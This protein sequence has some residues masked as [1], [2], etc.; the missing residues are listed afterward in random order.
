MIV[1]S[2]RPLEKQPDLK[3]IIEELKRGLL[4]TITYFSGRLYIEKVY[5]EAQ[6]I[7]L[8]MLRREASLRCS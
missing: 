3:K 2:I 1:A 7:Q 6:I 4:V 5:V 8:D